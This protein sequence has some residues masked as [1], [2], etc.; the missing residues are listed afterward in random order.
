[1][2]S[3]QWIQGPSLPFP[4]TEGCI[5]SL[6]DEES[7]HMLVGGGVTSTQYLQR[8]Y[9]YNWNDT[10]PSWE[11][12]GALSQPRKTLACARVTLDIGE[13]VVAAGGWVYPNIVPVTDIYNI[14][15]ET[16]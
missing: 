8:A 16:W 1:M 3:W 13:V 9:I 14:A 4:V 10:V 7:M 11:D 6:N 12:A 15:S 2:K 5:I